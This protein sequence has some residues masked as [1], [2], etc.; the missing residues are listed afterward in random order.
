VKDHKFIIRAKE[1]AG[2]KGKHRSFVKETHTIPYIIPEIP[3]NA[4]K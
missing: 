3:R 1:R 4:I 2:A